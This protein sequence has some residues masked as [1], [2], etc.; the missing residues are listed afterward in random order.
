ML[1]RWIRGVVRRRSLVLAAW[2]VVALAGVLSATNLSSL[3]TTSLDVPG[4]ASAHADTLLARHFHENV[5]GTFTVVLT[6]PRAIKDGGRALRSRVARAASFL[7]DVSVSPARVVGRTFYANVDTSEGLAAAAAATA[8]LRQR[9]R[10]D[11]LAGAQVTGAPALEYDIAPVLRADLRRGV[12]VSVTVAVLLLV[13]MLG[14]S[15]VVL[16]PLLVAGATTALALLVVFAL[17]HWLVMALYVPNVIELVG[18]GLAVDYSLLIVHRFRRETAAGRTCEDAL[19]ATMDAAGRT[20]L[21]S[22]M[23]V[24][25]GL[26]AL[27]LVPVPF[28]RSLAIAGLLVPVVAML[29]ALTL[30][31]ALV[32]LWGRR[33]VAA[34]GFAGVLAPRVPLDGRWARLTRLVLARRRVALAGAVV[35][36]AALA[37][38]SWWLALTPASLAALPSSMSSAQALDALSARF[39]PGVATP[40]EIVIDTGRAG[41]ADAASQRAARLRLARIILGDPEVEVVAIGDAAPYVGGDGRYEQIYVVGRSEFGAAASQALVT[42]I[43]SSDVRRAD[44]PDG[45][46]V[47]VGGAAAQGLDFLNSVYGVAPWIVAAAL[48]ISYL[49]LLRAFRSVWLPLLSAG[50]VLVSLAASYGALVA[51]FRFGWGSRL[52]GTYHVA[53]VEGWVPIFLFALLFGLSSDYQVFIVARVREARLAGARHDEAIVEGM[54]HTGGVVTA[55]AVI[56][57]G[58]LAGLVVGHVAGLQEL[59]VGLAVGVLVDVTLV[60]GVVLPSVM[61]LLGPACW[62]V[63]GWVA[64]IVRIPPS[65]LAAGEDGGIVEVARAT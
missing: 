58:A 23:V 29:G 33:G 40:I 3:L 22:G 55:A 15:W 62:W 50:L 60:R 10:H 47:V 6:S 24:A 21:T 63:P 38:S 48:V 7:P 30:Q 49:V 20:V 35:V 52:L 25:A 1:E 61:G 65:S 44:M 27:F 41:G 32:S 8:E 26:V 64:R 46:S 11:G 13:L 9:L 5:D 14:F 39:G 51:V 56:M 53:Q 2:V 42:L 54:A 19:V 34:H 31:P 37:A 28:V 16:V 17:A 59:G 45:T 43:R 4:T 18:L 12:V 57:V 36:L